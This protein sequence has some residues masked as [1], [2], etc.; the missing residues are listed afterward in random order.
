MVAPKLKEAMVARAFYSRS[1][2]V[3]ARDLLGKLLIHHLNGARLTGLI[4][5]VEARTWPLR[6]SV[7]CRYRFNSQ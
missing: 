5:E 4:V 6:S 3:V 7:A 2:E 1:P